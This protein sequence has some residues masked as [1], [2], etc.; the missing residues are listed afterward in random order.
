MV[1]DHDR[2][3]ACCRRSTRRRWPTSRRS[4]SRSTSPGYDPEPQL[5]R[6]LSCGAPPASPT[7]RAKVNGGKLE[8]SW[9]EFFEPRP[10][11][12]GKIG[13][14]D[15]QRRGVRGRRASISAST[16]APRTRRT[17][18]RSS[19]C[20]QRRSRSWQLY[21]SDGT[22]ER[23]IAGE[24][25]MQQQWNGASHRTKVGLPTAVYVYPEGGA[26][27]SGATI[28][29]CRRARRNVDNA[30]IF[31]NWIMAPKNIAEAS[32]F[33]ATTTPSG[34]RRVAVGRAARRAGGEHAARHAGTA[35][36]DRHLRPASLDLRDKV[37]TRLRR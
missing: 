22:I 7:T 25:A 28:S 14:L 37:W 27:T 10:E 15:D 23:M 34:F 9:K 24:V 11:L 2:A 32:N 26:R 6:A 20:C 29:R 5:H 4:R 21:N 33:P 13:M 16:P 35:A 31:I 30:K 12:V 8:E 18:R 3:T 17:P 1:Q 19:T 36:P